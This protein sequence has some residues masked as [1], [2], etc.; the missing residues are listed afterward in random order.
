MAN[1]TEAWARLD[2]HVERH[3]LATNTPGIALA[4]TDKEKVLHTAVFGHAD[5]ARQVPLTA[6]HLFEIGSVGKSFTAIALLQL[7][8]EGKLDLHQPITHYLPWFKVQSRYEPITVHHLLCH[9][10][11]LTVGADVSGDMRFAAWV[12]R[13][14]E[15]GFA[16]G[17]H[18]RYSN[19][20]YKLLGVLLQTLTG[21]SYAETM[22]ERILRP[23]QMTRTDPVITHE[24]RKRLAQAGAHWYDDR[25]HH[26]TH[27]IVPATWLETATP[28]GCLAS[29]AEDMAIYLQMLL[30]GGAPLL[31]PES[32]ALLTSRAIELEKDKSYYGY[33]LHTTVEENGTILIG[34]GGG[35][36]GYST[37]MQAD[38]DLGIGIIALMTQP[39]TYGM[40]PYF[41]PLLQAGMNG[42][43]LPEVPPLPDQT[44][45]KNCADYVGQYQCGEKVLEITAADDHLF[46]HVNSETILLEN[47][48]P[49]HFFAHHPDFNL[50][51]LH[52]GREG[53]KDGPV[54]EL[55]YGNDWY[56]NGRYQGSTEFDIPNE[57][58]AY[59]G[60]YR[61]H[62]PW[63]TN[64]R[65]V[66][67]KG[68]LWHI[69]PNGS[70]SKM[71]DLGDG[72][73]R[74]G[75][76]DHSPERLQFDSIVNGEA[77]R[78]VWPGNAFYRFFTP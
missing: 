52:F 67:R 25:P 34:H 12:L 46:L 43:P 60:H 23:L 29:T 74:F 30:N 41:W 20:G 59:P 70:G 77:W 55:F 26:H 10:A 13:E 2:R 5:L 1:L 6:D 16:P 22:T 45:V 78:A 8:G 44:V 48:Q 75:N 36:V 49:D 65:I 51:L 9:S 4:I 62:N 32:Y 53:E 19:A 58:L 35:M 71:V 14:T 18:H 3:R 72:R 63:Y 69:W 28:D 38:M 57:W 73:F 11:G 21:Q 64:F 15:T 24:T 7:V 54:V 40:W 50:F 61:C 39:G 68:E 31:T 47:R 33:G 27:G 66:L 17:E 76:G 56:V 42:E 37:I